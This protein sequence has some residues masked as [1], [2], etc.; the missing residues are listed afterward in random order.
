MTRKA[1]R[2][3]ERGSVLVA[4]LMLVAMLATL[5]AIMAR[6]S[7]S[8]A[9]ISSASREQHLR[10]MAAEAIRAELWSCLQGEPPEA[11]EGTCLAPAAGWTRPAA[12]TYRR[13]WTA[14]GHV[15]RVTAAFGAP[16]PGAARTL[17]IAVCREGVDCA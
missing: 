2:K 16:A 7:F 11:R 4:V 13:A 14:S 10:V 12:G 8:R 3:G 1:K 9:S 15:F 17:D 6:T 5:T